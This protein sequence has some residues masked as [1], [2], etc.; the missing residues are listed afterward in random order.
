MSEKSS[1]TPGPWHYQEGADAYAHIVRAHGNYFL[2]Q[3]AQD[4]S[5]TAEA[6]ARLIAAAPEL[7]DAL[8]D[9]LSEANVSTPTRAKAMAAINKAINGV[10]G[11]N[12]VGR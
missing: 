3:L 11:G 9:C 1:H 10:K 12:G 8:A 7:L 2:C 4:T 6:N 5:G